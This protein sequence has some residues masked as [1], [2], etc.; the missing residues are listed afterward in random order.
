MNQHAARRPLRLALVDDHAVVRAGLRRLLELEG[1][2]AVVAEYGNGDELIA[3]LATPAAAYAELLVLDLWMPGHSGPE[4]VRRIRATETAP[5]VLVFTMHD[6]AAM[7]EQCLAAGALG[8]VTKSS[9]P[10]VLVDAIRR[11]ARG[12]IALSPDM[13]ALAEAGARRRPPHA[14]L[15]V[16]EMEV[17]RH[18]LAGKTVARIAETLQV[19]AKTIANHQSRIRDVLGVSGAV[20]L[21]H[22][23][24]DHGLLDLAAS[25]GGSKASA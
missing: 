20:E 12:E 9:D 22:Y 25:F 18:L 16:R 17:L 2:M 11:A 24:R 4:L 10:A 8:F 23:G 19:S 14:R 13:A 21:L 7:L 6:S 5:T 3:A 15:T 1:D